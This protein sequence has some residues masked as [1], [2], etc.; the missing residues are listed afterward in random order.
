MSV[1]ISLVWPSSSI[2]AAGL[3]PGSSRVAH[4][5]SVRAEEASVAIDQN[6]SGSGGAVVD[7]FGWRSRD[8]GPGK[9]AGP[10]A[11]FRNHLPETHERFHDRGMVARA[12][13]VQRPRGVPE[14]SGD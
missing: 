5:P 6:S 1:S 13:E 14:R 12:G 3:P 8:L 4:S 2:T 9:V 10:E 7:D 11:V